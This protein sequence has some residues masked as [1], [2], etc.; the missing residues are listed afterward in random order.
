MAPIMAC[1]I[2]RTWPNLS[3]ETASGPPRHLC[4]WA[5]TSGWKITLDRPAWFSLSREAAFRFPLA[6]LTGQFRL[7][8]RICLISVVMVVVVVSRRFSG[9]SRAWHNDK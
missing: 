7:P 1:I 5:A 3:T 2:R 4:G 6:H 8:L 9:N